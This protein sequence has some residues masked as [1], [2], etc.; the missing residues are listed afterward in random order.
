MFHGLYITH[1]NI[2]WFTVSIF[3]FVFLIALTIRRWP[4]SVKKL[5]IEF[6]R[7]FNDILYTINQDCFV[8][9]GGTSPLLDRR[10]YMHYEN[11]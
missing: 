4:I 7:L 8:N 10:S 2:A 5:K 9:E 3:V 6:D 1:A 11:L